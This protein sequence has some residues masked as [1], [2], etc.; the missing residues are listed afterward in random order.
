M[1]DTP[2]PSA[3][4]CCT[5]L[6]DDLHA[7]GRRA[8]PL[9]TPNNARPVPAL[10]MSFPQKRESRLSKCHCEPFCQPR[11]Q[12]ARQSLRYSLPISPLGPP[13]LGDKK[14][15]L[16]TP[17]TPAGGFS[18]FLGD[19]LHAPG[20]RASPLCTPGNRTGT[21]CRV[22]TPACGGRQRAAALFSRSIMATPMPFSSVFSMIISST[23]SSS[24]SRNTA[25]I[26]LAYSSSSWGMILTMGR[27]LPLGVK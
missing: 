5:F 26:C 14:G 19:D 11:E 2:K 9:C 10:L 15:Y 8:S 25:K 22:P 1:G 18:T 16:G 4:F 23:A 21:A 20:R 27:A 7:P 3:A 13:L 24:S 6:G 17:Q 12:K